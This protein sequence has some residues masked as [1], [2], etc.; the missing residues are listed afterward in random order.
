M[1]KLHPAAIQRS[2]E[3]CNVARAHYNRR[4]KIVRKALNGQWVAVAASL[5]INYLLALRSEHEMGGRDE[6]QMQMLFMWI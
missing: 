2:N 4:T 1:R 5:S 3:C 6:F